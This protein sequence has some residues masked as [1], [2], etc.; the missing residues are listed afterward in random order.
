MTRFKKECIKRGFEYE[1]RF[2]CLPYRLPNGIVIETIQ[3]NAA[4]AT[5]TTVYNVLVVI[6]QVNRDFTVTDL[7]N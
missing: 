4:L 5:I 3:Y 7:T 1:E 2:P 6:C